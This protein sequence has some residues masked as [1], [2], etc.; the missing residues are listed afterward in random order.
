[1][2]ETRVSTEVSVHPLVLLSKY[3]HL[4]SRTIFSPCCIVGVV[5]HY[6]RVAKDTQR[7]VVGVLLGQRVKDR[8]DI[9]NSFAVPFEEDLRNPEVWFLD[10]NFLETMYWMFKKVN[11]ECIYFD[12]SVS[13]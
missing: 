6:H 2:A 1:M 9:S 5:D 7:R 13:S 8:I 11:S 4:H 12:F 3:F 10:H